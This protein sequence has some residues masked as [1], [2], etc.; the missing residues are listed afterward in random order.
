MQR[1]NLPI[2]RWVRVTREA[3]LA[4]RTHSNIIRVQFEM[5]GKQWDYRLMPLV[6][7]LD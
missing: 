4:A 6:D 1:L 3:T 7:L 5:L 2:D